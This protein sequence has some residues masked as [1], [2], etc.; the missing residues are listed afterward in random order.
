[1]CHRQWDSFNAGHYK[2]ASTTVLCKGCVLGETMFESKAYTCEES[3]DLETGL[4]APGK[5][6]THVA[7][8]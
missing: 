4:G 1:M 5:F 2:A 3:P 6:N 8:W 7:I